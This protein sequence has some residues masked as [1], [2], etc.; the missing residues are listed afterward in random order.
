MFIARNT[1]EVAILAYCEQIGLEKH[2]VGP[3]H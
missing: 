2:Q 1:Y 3:P